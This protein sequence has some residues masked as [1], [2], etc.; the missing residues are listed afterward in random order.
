MLW[1]LLGTILHC[2]LFIIVI[3]KK[4]NW[5]TGTEKVDC[6][7]NF[8]NPVSLS[9]SRKEAV[10]FLNVFSGCA[11]TKLGDVCYNCFCGQFWG[12]IVRC[13]YRGTLKRGCLS[14]RLYLR[15]L[16]RRGL[17]APG[18][19]GLLGVSVRFSAPLPSSGS[20]QMRGCKTGPEVTAWWRAWMI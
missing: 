13:V 5:K 11:S 2:P 4:L 19:V 17:A 7:A 3:S 20:V 9:A 15:R 1:L 18:A 10:L 12:V 14:V 16:L 6:R 8:G